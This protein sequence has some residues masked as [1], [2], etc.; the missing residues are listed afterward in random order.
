MSFTSKDYEKL[1]KLMDESSENKELIEKLMEHQ[2][3]TISKISHEIRNPLA[4]VYSTLQLIETQHPEAKAFKH[5]NDMREDIE[6]MNSL[7]T[8]LS[9]YNNG[10]RL[11]LKSFSSHDLLSHVCLSFASSCM[12]SEVEFTSKIEDSL[13]D[14]TGDRIKL[15]EVFLNLLKNAFEA[16]APKGSIRLDAYCENNVL[17]IKICDSGCG[18]S[19]EQ[20]DGIFDMFVTHKT[21]GTGLG[22]AIAKRTIEAHQGTITVESALQNGSVFTI[23]LPVS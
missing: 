10:E 22:L 16:T 6:F 19:P 20:I 3:Y 23:S 4:L 21:N 15:Q 18:I 9:A 14:I 2:Q 13:P 17:K 1:K 11:R 5:W 7:L 8:E 12:D